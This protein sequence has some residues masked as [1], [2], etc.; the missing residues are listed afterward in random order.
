MRNK[1]LTK[2][3]GM[4][5]VL[6]AVR[7]GKPIKPKPV[8]PK[9]ANRMVKYLKFLLEK[10][11]AIG[12]RAVKEKL[13]LLARNSILTEKENRV[14]RYRIEGKTF[15]QIIKVAWEKPVATQRIRQIETKALRKLWKSFLES[16]PEEKAKALEEQ[17]MEGMI[18][19]KHI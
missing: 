10:E 8:L 13:Y 4:R 18:G 17:W 1:T 3:K 2:R 16:L 12:P 19:Q 14:L 6:A 11:T 7:R 5:T 9:T 15:V